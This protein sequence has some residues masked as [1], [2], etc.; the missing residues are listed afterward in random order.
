MFDDVTDRLPSGV[1]V[2]CRLPI[3]DAHAVVQVLTAVGVGPGLG[4]GRTVYV[5]DVAE[6]AHLDCA[7]PALTL[8]AREIPRTRL[9]P[10][11][12]PPVPTKSPDYQCVRCGKT[13]ERG[14]RFTQVYRAEGIAIDPETKAPGLRCSDGYE[15]A[16]LDC[17]DPQIKG[18]GAILLIGNA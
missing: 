7:K 2:R 3:N 6:A 1:C 14:D 8:T 4:Y 5:N 10:G 18:E 15:T 17:S 9:K 13:Y 16:H 11:D 12:P